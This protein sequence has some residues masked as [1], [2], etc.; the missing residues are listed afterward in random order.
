VFNTIAGLTSGKA[1]KLD[2]N[3]YQNPYE[4][5]ALAALPSQYRIDP[6]LNAYRN[7]YANY[8]RNVNNT[9]NSRGERMAGYGAGMNQYNEAAGNAYAEKNNQENSMAIRRAMMMNEQGMQRAGVNLNVRNM[10]DQNAAA[11]RNRQMGYLGA[12][13]S[14]FQRYG[15]TQQQMGNQQTSQMAYINALM[16]GDPRMRNF[17]QSIFPQN[18]TTGQ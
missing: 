5:Q 4:Q 18:N 16:K 14:D 17:Y 9:S 2:P 12:A 15:L 8:T 3:A 1:Q 11:A 6:Q 10:N 13:A 7:A